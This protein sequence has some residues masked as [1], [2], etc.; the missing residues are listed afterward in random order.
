MFGLPIL[1]N[2]NAYKSFGTILFDRFLNSLFLL[3]FMYIMFF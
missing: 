1:D 2:V 3:H